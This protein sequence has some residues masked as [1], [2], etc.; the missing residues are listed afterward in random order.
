MLLERAFLAFHNL[1]HQ[2]ALGT[3]LIAHIGRAPHFANTPSNRRRK[4]HFQDQGITGPYHMFELAIVDFDEISIVLPTPAKVDCK[5]SP[6]LGQ[7]F[8]LQYPGHHRIARKMTLEKPFVKCHI[9]DP[10]NMGIAEFNDFVHQRKRK[11][12][13]LN[14]RR[15]VRE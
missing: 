14:V 10:D 15:S 2:V 3:Y 1:R 4:L 5:N 12:V 7:G 13:G 8:N 9:L 6:A 11:T